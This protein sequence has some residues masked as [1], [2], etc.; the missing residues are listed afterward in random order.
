[1]CCC[2]VLSKHLWH[3]RAHH[4]VVLL[5]VLLVLLKLVYVAART[6]YA[7][8]VISI[9]K[10]KGWYGFVSEQHYGI[11]HHHERER[12]NHANLSEDPLYYG[13]R[14]SH[15]VTH[16]FVVSSPTLPSVFASSTACRPLLPDPSEHRAYQIPKQHC[17][18]WWKCCLCH[19]PAH[20]SLLRL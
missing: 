16:C 2:T 12:D 15:Y 9:N 8:R 11:S 1:M 10:R 3:M 6:V 4:P 13:P 19:K 20:R 7:V 5:L 17:G 14:P 18:R